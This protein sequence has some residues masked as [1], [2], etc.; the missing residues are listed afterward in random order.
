MLRACTASS[1][2]YALPH[3]RGIARQQYLK[4]I[5]CLQAHAKRRFPM[6][7]QDVRVIK[8]KKAIRDALFSI[9]AAKPINKI[10]IKEISE[11]AGI[12]RKTFYSH[13]SS[14]EDI[15]TEMENELVVSIDSYLKNCIIAEYGLNPYYFIQFINAI[16]SSNPDFC[17]SLVSVHNYH[18]LAEKIKKVFK[19]QLT[20]SMKLPEK[21]RYIMDFKIE[22]YLSGV[23]S[24]YIDWIKQ[25]KP[26]PFEE[27]S[28]IINNLVL[29]QLSI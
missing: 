22:F 7:E 23:S 18:F 14:I 9:L 6:N 25:G 21:D 17:E 4:R 8:S 3:R 20:D 27:L 2:T 26:C 24:V 28:A 19:K 11:T 29:E 10:T 12:N 1:L 13:Y 15:I 5:D 16:Y